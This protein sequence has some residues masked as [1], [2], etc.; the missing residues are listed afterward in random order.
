[1]FPYPVVFGES[2]MTALLKLFAAFLIAAMTLPSI[3]L[4]S[5][6][7]RTSCCCNASGTCPLRKHAGCAKSCS[8]TSSDAAPASSFRVPELARDP[9]VFLTAASGFE[10]TLSAL[11]AGFAAAPLYRSSPP[12]LPPP[13]A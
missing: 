8:M 11:V 10:P 12:A 6:T 4:L 3:A 13:R 2:I 9:A 1:M 7:A 5:T